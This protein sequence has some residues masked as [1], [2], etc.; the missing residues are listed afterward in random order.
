LDKQVVLD[1]DSIKLLTDKVNQ[2]L[3]KFD[4]INQEEKYKYDQF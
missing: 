1:Q 4:E 3:S 2:I